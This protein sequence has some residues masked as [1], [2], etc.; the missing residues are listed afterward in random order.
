MDGGNGKFEALAARTYAR[1]AGLA[2]RYYYSFRR[3]SVTRGGLPCMI[4]LGNHSSGKSSLVNWVLGGEP[5]QDVGLAPTDDGFTICVFGEMEEDVCGPAALSRLPAEFRTLESF[6]DSFLQHLKVKVRNRARLRSVMLVDSPGMIDSAEGTVSRTYDFAGVVRRLSEICDMVFFLLDPEKPGTTGET[7]TIFSKCLAGVEF[8]LRVL[9]NKC[10]A[11]SGLY[12]F[13]RTYGT[14]CWN[15]AR[16]LHTKDLPKIWTLYSG[17]ERTDA[18]FDLSDFNRH[19]REFL[20]VLDDAAARR[21][22]NIYAQTLADFLGLS[23]RMRVVNH[24]MRALVGF[25]A[26]FCACTALMLGGGGYLLW[27]ALAAHGSLF[28]ALAVGAA[29][30]GGLVAAG[31]IARVAERLMRLSLSRRVDEIFEKEYRRDLAV[32]TCEEIR[33]LWALTREETAKIVLDA[34]L[35]LPLLGEFR[36]RRLDAAAQKVLKAF[37]TTA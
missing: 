6:G 37:H 23:V 22:D 17:P 13:A 32:G 15:L 8:K 34:P 29:A 16:V 27:Q 4:L 18:G 33:Q 11:F 3:S 36:R 30:V 24:A 35:D 2:E 20:A 31:L 12:D 28:A 7:V 19:R 9:L 1:F 26:L 14:T 21:K 25:R 5:V 10:D